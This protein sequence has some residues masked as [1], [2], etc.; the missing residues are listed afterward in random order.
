MITTYF[1]LPFIC[2]PFLL[3]IFL[4]FALFLIMI[5]KICIIQLIYIHNN[6]KNYEY[7]LYINNDNFFFEIYINNNNIING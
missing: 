6:D 2:C 1:L 7:N 5:I 4:Y 3:K